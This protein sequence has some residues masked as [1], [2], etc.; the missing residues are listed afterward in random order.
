MKGHCADENHARTRKTRF[1]NDRLSS[2]VFCQPLIAEQA[3]SD[4]G[5]ASEDVNSAMV[6]I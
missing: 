6:G 4:A 3:S 2:Y 5:F 1:L